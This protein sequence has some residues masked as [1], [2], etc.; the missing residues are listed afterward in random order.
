MEEVWKTIKKYKDYQISNFG[1]VKSLR[2]GNRITILR[3]RDNKYGYLGV[4]LYRDG[5][6]RKRVKIHRLVAEEFLRKKKGKMCVNHIDGNK[7]NNNANNLEWTTKSE[8]I[9]HSYRIKLHI[10]NMVN[11]LKARRQNY[12][13]RLANKKLFI[14]QNRRGKTNG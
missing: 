14:R 12:E 7:K 5:E 9:K 8:D 13:K 11:A 3:P 10:P 4:N 6:K 2:W 1:N